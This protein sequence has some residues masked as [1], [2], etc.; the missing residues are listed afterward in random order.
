M[1]TQEKKSELPPH[2]E[3]RGPYWKHLLFRR[4]VYIFLTIIVCITGYVF[5][6]RYDD[7]RT[8][9]V[10]G[11][12][13][14]LPPHSVFGSGKSGGP[15]DLIFTYGILPGFDNW[16]RKY[17]PYEIS[18]NPYIVEIFIGK[19][20][21]EFDVVANVIRRATEDAALREE[22]PIDDETLGLRIY[23]YKPGRRDI[24]VPSQP[25]R[26][27]IIILCL[28]KTSVCRGQ[29]DRGIYYIKFDFH[30]DH[31]ANWRDLSNTVL[32]HIDRSRSLA[33]NY[34]VDGND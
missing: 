2:E 21:D 25:F 31:L 20:R 33:Q 13:F 7:W 3:V 30:R 24:R 29:V 6:V 19:D 28:K 15:V 26:E 1:F 16:D 4:S 18:S 11:V 12:E 10:N 9:S 23:P 8:Y 14:R 17:R 32:A 27:P 22:R 5:W 34:N